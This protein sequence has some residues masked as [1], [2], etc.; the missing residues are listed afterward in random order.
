[1]TAT[2]LERP[3][4]RLWRVLSGALLA[5]VTVGATVVRT[6]SRPLARHLMDHAYG[7]L[8]LGCIDAAA[9]V[10]SP[11]TGLLVTGISLLV[12][13]WKVSD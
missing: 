1:M 9:F 4:R 11:F 5:A 10:H 8:G 2:T 13:E 3:T 6:N 12:F 7:I